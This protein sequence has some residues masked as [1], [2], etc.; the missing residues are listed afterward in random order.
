MDY[1]QSTVPVI[2][3]RKIKITGGGDTGDVSGGGGDDDSFV[4]SIT[5]YMYF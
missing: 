5:K 4:D 3:Q 1:W 2:L